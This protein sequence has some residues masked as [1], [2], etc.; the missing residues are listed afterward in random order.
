M[1]AKQAM[2]VVKYDDATELATLAYE[3]GY[4]VTSHLEGLTKVNLMALAKF[5]GHRFVGRPPM[6]FGP[7]HIR[8]AI[9][10]KQMTITY[11]DYVKSRPEAPIPTPTASP[12]LT[13]RLN[14]ATAALA[15]S[16]TAVSQG[17]LDA[18][19]GGM[20]ERLV[21]AAMG[22]H[23]G[24]AVAE[25]MDG[26]RHEITSIVDGL[27]PNV[28]EVKVNTTPTVKIDGP[29]HAQFAQVLSAVAANVPM[30]LVGPA[31]SGK[32]TICE[33]V[34]KSMGLGFRVVNCTAAMTEYKVTGY[35]DANGV[36]A[37][38]DF[39]D[40]FENGGV[41]VMDEIDN[42]NPNT[43]GVL[44]SALANGYM[45]FPDGMVKRHENFRA[46]ACAN[47]FGTGATMQY[48][49]RNPIDAATIDR[50]AQLEIG[51]D[52][53][54]E[55]AMLRSV[56]LPDAAATKWLLAI[57]TARRN[58]ET[59]G[60]KVIVSPRATLHG[61][62]LIAAGWTPAQAFQAKVTNGVKADQMDKIM[63]GVA[64]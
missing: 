5:L 31:G 16:T 34:A 47:T 18:A 53:N 26:F 52:D 1:S 36:Y 2:R 37:A 60:L 22:G 13:A 7:A 17:S 42:A 59:N 21:Q 25:A 14:A 43:L 40:M 33:Q 54:V 35:R 63:A 29:V 10:S 41:F 6:A 55:L 3:S 30:W 58:V 48:V 12:A 51:Y 23:V 4:T 56:G 61:A 45:A 28:T 39:R 20:V 49:G 15:P 57:R 64:L 19:F 62:R 8:E 44:N 27:R 24:A 11:G 9:R 38:T 50:F 46:I 32:T